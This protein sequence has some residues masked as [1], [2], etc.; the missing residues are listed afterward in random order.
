M[1]YRRLKAVLKIQGGKG[2]EGT[3]WASERSREEQRPAVQED[4]LQE[5]D[6]DREQSLAEQ[7]GGS[8]GQ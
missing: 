1:A 4:R 7:N 2:T 6:L 3:G 5:E 8:H